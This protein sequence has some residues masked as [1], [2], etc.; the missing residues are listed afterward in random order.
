MLV[1]LALPETSRII[2]GNG[3][4]LATGIHRTFLSGLIP[5]R[6]ALGGGGDVVPSPPGR[7][8]AHTSTLPNPLACLKLLLVK[9]VAGIILCNGIYY[10]INCCLQASLSTL[11]IEVCGYRT[12]EA[13]LIYIPYGFGCV[14]NTFLWGMSILPQTS[15]LPTFPSEGI[16]AS[17]LGRF[18]DFSYARTARHHGI[19]L[20]SARQGNHEGLPI[21]KARLTGGL[22]LVTVAT[23]AT[24]GYGWAIRYRAVRHPYRS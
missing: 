11:F 2:V 18:L 9:D 24:V 1:W 21:R 13:G 20:D 7:R 8:D 6:K 16:N 14:V 17:P 3:S 19:P 22:Y 4:G 15:D 23:A 10:T 12:L 5:T